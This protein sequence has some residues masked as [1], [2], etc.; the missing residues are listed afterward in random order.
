MVLE[1]NAI[2]C[3]DCLNKLKDI[4]DE[5]V[6]LIYIDPPF[7]SN[8]NYV[9][10]WEEQEVRHFEDRFEDVRAYVDY[11]TP[12]VRE[13]YRVLKKTGSF[14]YHCDWHASHYI[15]VLLDRD[16]LFGYDNFLNEV[17]WYYKRW[18]A[19][20]KAYQRFHDNILFYAKNK[21]S[22][23]FIPPLED[24]AEITMKI[25]KGKKQQA[26]VIDGHRWSKDSE[27]ATGKTQMGDTWYISTIAGNAHERLGY[28]T[29]KPLLLLDRIINASSNEGDIVLDAFC[30]CGTALASA[31][32][33]KRKWIGIDISPTACRVVSQRLSKDYGL[34]EGTDYYVRNMPM[35]VEELRVYPAFEFQ[36]WAIIALGGTPNK[37][38]VRDM[39][40]DGK[41]Y[42]IE[43]ISKERK[44]VEHYPNSQNLF[45]DIDR[46]IPIQVK[47]TDQVGR[48]DIDAFQTAMK[49]DGRNMGIF[50]G[51]SFSRDAEKEIRRM[52]REEN[53]EIEMVTV[54]ELVKSQLDKQIG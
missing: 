45:G 11:M 49:R 10:F 47:R 46:Y 28:P 35:T 20:S 38:R 6:D 48:P 19:K 29:Q 42:P 18:P 36:N 31:Q 13:L 43:Q 16:D 9:A 32:N 3:G 54:D 30:G 27:E 1:T 40:I 4:P 21:G 51:F 33:N 26:L 15:K 52:A 22:H 23:T 24:I 5:S 2:Y 44:T 14:Y 37:A 53:L 34:K 25:H 41:L 17:I 50:V 8:R 12:R 7:S 39:G